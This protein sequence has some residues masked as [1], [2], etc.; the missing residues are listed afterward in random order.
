[1]PSPLAHLFISDLRCNR[2]S[3][4]LE[5]NWI[6]GVSSM[7]SMGVVLLFFGGWSCELDFKSLK[8]TCKFN[9]ILTTDSIFGSTVVDNREMILQTIHFLHAA[10]TFHFQDHQVAPWKAFPGSFGHRDDL[11]GTLPCDWWSFCSWHRA[12]RISMWKKRL[13]WGCNLFFETTRG[14]L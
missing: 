12:R 8:N 11:N 2:G 3:C 6:D 1:M 13:C 14:C 5:T 7:L 4:K 9:I 10:W